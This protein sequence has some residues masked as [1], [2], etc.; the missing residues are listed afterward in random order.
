MSDS[1]AIGN[2]GSRRLRAPVL[3]ASFLLGGFLLLPLLTIFPTSVTSASFL[4]FPPKGFSTRWYE[5]VLSDPVWRDS[6]WYSIR[7]ALASAALATVT[8]TSAALGARRLRSGSRALRTFFLA[9]IVFPGIVYVFGLY[10][11]FDTLR[12]IGMTLPI[13]VGQACLAFPV[14]FMVVFASLSAINPALFRASESLGAGWLTTVLRIELPLLKLSIVGAFIFAFAASF[15]E[16]MVALFVGGFE[17]V[18]L[19]VEIFRAT[20]ESAAPDIAAVSA[21]VT[22]GALVIIGLCMTMLRRGLK[23]Q[24]RMMG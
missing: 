15:D 3:I 9:P 5:A 6:I 17:Q 16:L 24:R 11:M 21:L 22:V 1:S 23:R 8:G 14:V 10:Q 7:I 2:F 4:S 13:V 19:P 20:K 18:T 12:M